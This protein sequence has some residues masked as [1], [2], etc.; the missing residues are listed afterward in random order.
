VDSKSNEITATGPLLSTVDIT[1]TVVTVDAL[2]TQRDFANVIVNQGGDYFFVVKEN[3]PTVLEQVIA[4]TT[5]PDSDF[6]KRIHVSTDA[7]H[8]RTE[9]RTLRVAPAIGVDFPHAAQAIRIRRDRGGTDGQRTSKEIVYAIT[10]L[11]ATDAGPSDLAGYARAHWGIENKLHWVRDAVYREDDSRVRTGNAP[12]VMATLRNIA[13]NTIRLT[14]N[15]HRI[16]KTLRRNRYD[17]NAT[18]AML[19]IN[20]NSPQ[21]HPQRT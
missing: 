6:E 1:G 4:A 3:Q 13:I 15:D 7:G 2:H 10:S 11:T 18:L 19:G 12:R 8:G 17:F 21:P 5:G 20:T 16:A 9:K 14:T